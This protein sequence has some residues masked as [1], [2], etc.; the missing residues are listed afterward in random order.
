M[1]IYY[2]VELLSNQKKKNE[3]GDENMRMFSVT[4]QVVTKVEMV[5]R[6]NTA[7]ECYSEFYEWL[8]QNVTKDREVVLQKK[9]RYLEETYEE[10]LSRVNHELDVSNKWEQ[11]ILINMCEECL[12]KLRRFLKNIMCIYEAINGI[13]VKDEFYAQYDDLGSWYSAQFDSTSRVLEKLSCKATSK[14]DK[15][16]STEY[17]DVMIYKIQDEYCVIV[18]KKNK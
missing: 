4:P 12:K 5:N 1:Q 11:L 2:N 6:T 7:V 8:S 17:K 18:N 14:N 3:G 10:L 13:E 16:N 9:L 15:F